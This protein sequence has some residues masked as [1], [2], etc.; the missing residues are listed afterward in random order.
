[1]EKESPISEVERSQAGRLFQMLDLS[2]EDMLNDK[3]GFMLV[4]GL[5][6][7]DL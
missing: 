6:L 3:E 7:D 1:M 5:E 4:R 2:D